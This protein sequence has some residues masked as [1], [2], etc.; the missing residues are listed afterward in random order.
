M[1]ATESAN[2]GKL[3]I[4]KK[5]SESLENQGETLKKHMN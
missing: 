3:S 1:V 5:V 4:F 2:P